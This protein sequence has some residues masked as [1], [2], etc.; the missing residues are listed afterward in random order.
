MDLKD[1]WKSMYLLEDVSYL[2]ILTLS[3]CCYFH[4]DCLLYKLLTLP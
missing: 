3:L 1:L 2:H 4:V